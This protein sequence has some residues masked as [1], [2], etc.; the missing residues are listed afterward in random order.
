M[1]QIE[2]R[3]PSVSPSAAGRL[4]DMLRDWIDR[5]PDSGDVTELR[6]RP[7][8][9]EAVATVTRD[10]RRTDVRLHHQFEDHWLLDASTLVAPPPPPTHGWSVLAGLLMFLLGVVVSLR[11]LTFGVGAFLVGVGISVG[12]ALLVAG[13]T[14]QRHADRRRTAMTRA[15]GGQLPAHELVDEIAQVLRSDTRVQLVGAS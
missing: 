6:V 3:I 9:A 4:A 8:G 11:W 15:E 10:G 2:L 5:I 12:V 13:M 14:G 7:D 1:Q